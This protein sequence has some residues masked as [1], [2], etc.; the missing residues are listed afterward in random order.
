VEF[1]S[2][3]CLGLGFNQLEYVQAAKNFGYHIIGFDGDENAVCRN[4]CDES[5]SIRIDNY[6]EIVEMLG[7]YE[8]LIGCISEQTDNALLTVGAVNST[9]N[10]PGPSLDLVH[11]IKDKSYQRIKCEKLGIEQPDFCLYESKQNFLRVAETFINQYKNIVIK[12]CEGQSSIAVR[13]FSREALLECN[14]EELFKNLTEI[15]G[16]KKFLVEEFVTGDDISIEGFVSQ[17][18]VYVLAVSHK[19]KF[20]NNPMVDRVLKVIPY[21]EHEHKP[22]HELA[23]KLVRGFSL[24]N[25]FFHIEAKKNGDSLSLI[26]W[27]VRGCG[28]RL[29][30]VLLS[31]M[32][33]ENMAAIRIGMLRDNYELPALECFDNIG[34]LQF[35]DHQNI[36]MKSLH[37]GI[38]KYTKNYVLHINNSSSSDFLGEH[39]QLLDGRSRP[40][41]II[42]VGANEIIE[43]LLTHMSTIGK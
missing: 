26:E 27:T 32:Y 29:S 35:F 31:K 41:N 37:S 33:D 19:T 1:K 36:Q 10:L 22:E 18:Q 12:P 14:S 23:C 8:N 25:S 9:F 40:S 6:S 39:S 20:E 30:S 21:G 17:S 7:K 4:L 34:L 42:A 13:S 38:E 28:A 15:S 5:Y 43:S 11:A 24:D 2:I 3:V 16:A